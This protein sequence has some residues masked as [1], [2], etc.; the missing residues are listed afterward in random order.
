MG[1]LRHCKPV[2]EFS[3]VSKNLLRFH[4]YIGKA[5]YSINRNP[6]VKFETAPSVKYL[7]H[8]TRFFGKFES[9]PFTKQTLVVF[10]FFDKI[11]R[12][13]GGDGFREEALVMH[14]THPHCVRVRAIA[15]K[16]LKT[17]EWED[18]KHHILAGGEWSE[19]TTKTGHL[20][21]R[22]WEIFVLDRPEVHAWYSVSGRLFVSSAL[23]EFYKTDA[24]VA[25]SIAHLMG[26]VVARHSLRE[27]ILESIPVKLC[28]LVK[29]G[30]T[31]SSYYNLYNLR[32]EQEADFIG[33]FLSASAG[34][35]P[36]VA[37]VVLGNQTSEDAPCPSMVKRMELISRPK[38]MQEA[39]AIYEES[40]KGQGTST[41]V[42][43]VAP[44]SRPQSQFASI[45]CH[46]FEEDQANKTP[47]AL[48]NQLKAIGRC[49]GWKTRLNGQVSPKERQSGLRSRKT[50]FRCPGFLPSDVKTKY[51]YNGIL[52]TS[53]SSSD[54]EENPSGYSSRRIPV[55]LYS[56]NNSRSTKVPTVVLDEECQH[57]DRIYEEKVDESMIGTQ[58]YFPS[59]DH[60]ESV[61]VY[62]I[63][64]ECLA[65]ETYLTS[66]IMNFYKR[67]L[68]QPT[69]TI[70]DRY[71][72]HFFTT[73]FYENLKVVQ[74]TVIPRR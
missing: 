7:G 37:L 22:E 30:G 67:H 14:D 16:L 25:F 40:I 59:R 36:R 33:M 3:G 8:L 38:V 1:F 35:D 61:E 69:A 43:Q 41:G 52:H 5:H 28:Y 29:H 45:F 63:D 70:D 53:P 57:V 12:V 47:G 34:Y 74:N 58:I 26:H 46:K 31:P 39:V 60:P 42:K 55:K 11:Y 48:G 9:V 6:V 32:H 13:L 19:E 17:L 4:K 56:S 15:E 21:G 23:C 66:T 49:D 72:Y 71:S 73:Y 68:Q 24:E 62:H 64:M 54:M 50:A 2:V 65:S 10:P 20:L 27:L 44:S 18:G 51:T